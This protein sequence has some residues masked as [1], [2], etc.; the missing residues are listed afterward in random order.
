MIYKKRTKLLRKKMRDMSVLWPT[1]KS[2]E[3]HL[4]AEMT[5]WVEALVT[6]LNNLSSVPGV[7]LVGERINCCRLSPGFYTQALENGGGG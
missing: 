1:Y 7:Y 5:Q 6:R 4:K 2:I 3:R